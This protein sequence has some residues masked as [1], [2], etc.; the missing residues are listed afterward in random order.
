MNIRTC[1]GTEGESL[2]VR[3]GDEYQLLYMHFGY[4]IDEK[5]KCSTIDA[6]ILE[7]P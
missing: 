6:H 5:P 2:I 4:E 7:Q 3:E 1:F